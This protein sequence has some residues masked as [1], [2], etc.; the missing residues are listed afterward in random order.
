MRAI[1]IF[2]FCQ[3][4]VFPEEVDPFKDTVGEVRKW[5][6]NISPSENT[7]QWF[8]EPS[9]KSEDSKGTTDI[10]FIWISTFRKPFSIRASKLKDKIELTV[11]RMKGLGGYDW[12]EVET[13]ETK[14]ITVQQWQALLR[15]IAVDGARKPSLRAKKSLRENWV[16][17][18]SA[19]DGS[20]WFLEVRDDSAYTVEGVPN[21]IIRDR[22]LAQKL[23]KDSGLDLDPFLAVCRELFEMSELN[24]KLDN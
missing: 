24:E 9:L 22:T 15:L 21:P 14:E 3:L 4:S 17:A 7:L 2:F 19:L 13:R 8:S 16:E 5:A 18:F 12:G 20:T 1:L 10:R 23:K 11:V 6:S